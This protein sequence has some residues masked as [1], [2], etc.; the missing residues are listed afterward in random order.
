MVSQMEG[1][2]QGE[3]ARKKRQLSVH[4]ISDDE[5]VICNEG[6]TPEKN[7]NTESSTIKMSFADVANNFIEINWIKCCEYINLQTKNWNLLAFTSDH[8]SA[9]LN[10]N[11]EADTQIILNIKELCLDNKTYE[12][13]IEKMVSTKNKGI[14]YNKLLS[15]FE[16][17]QIRDALKEQGIKSY[18]RLQKVDQI[19]GKKKFTGSIIINFEEEIPQQIIISKIVIVVNHLTPKIMIC[20]HCGMLGHTSFRCSK[21]SVKICTKCFSQ[22]DLDNQCAIICKNCKGDHISTDL[23]CPMLVKEMHI[24]RIK[25]RLDLNYFDAKTVASSMASHKK[26]DPLDEARAR[27]QEISYK[28]ELMY[29]EGKKLA[30]ENSRLKDLLSEKDE[31]IVQLKT[32]I[33]STEEKFMN[34]IDS[35]TDKLLEG[36]NNYK[37]LLD[38]TNEL[39]KSYSH[40]AD[41]VTKL[42]K[43]KN[44]DT[45][46]M[47][48]FI[49]SNDV[50]T[51][52]YTNF[53]SNKKNGNPTLEIKLKREPRPASLEKHT[54]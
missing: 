31:E 48:N 8:K 22:H 42:K 36:Q 11:S 13:K 33:Q 43:E 30:E 19:S 18:H 53:I 1:I 35:L 10:G 29:K 14:I 9:L 27:V 45:K 50:I 20:Y 34:D 2:T 24:L 4:D 40:A 54:K 49:N 16:E 23:K 17:N 12:V 25:E 38:T 41:L 3:P 5:N 47:E 28:N 39:K 32:D 7:M 26:L 51:K 37:T 46:I 52:A 44:S 15:H 6:D 21:I